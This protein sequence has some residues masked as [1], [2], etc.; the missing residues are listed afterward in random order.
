MARTTEI[1][2]PQVDAPPTLETL[3][4]LERQRAF[5]DGIEICAERFPGDE[6]RRVTCFAEV[7]SSTIG[8]RPSK[9][10]GTAIPADSAESR[11]R[12]SAHAHAALRAK[13]EARKAA[14]SS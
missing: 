9:R 2:V 8:R 10:T 3:E 11:R 7:V 5:I 12:G 14:A 6:E 13:R 4:G 1:D